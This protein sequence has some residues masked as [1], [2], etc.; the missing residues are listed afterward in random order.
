MIDPLSDLPNE[1]A[2]FST[3]ENEIA[4]AYTSW[5][6]L[7]VLVIDF[8][9]PP[10]QELSGSA[11]YIKNS[12]RQMDTLAISATGEFLVLLPAADDEAGREVIRRVRSKESIAPGVQHC[13][14]AGWASFGPDG[15][16]P[17]QLLAAARVR[18][19]GANS[20]VVFFP[21]EPAA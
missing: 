8:E 2:F 9:K 1:R 12:L 15:E 19:S 3:L 13:I 11:L 4:R 14:R 20:N 18:K 21:A 6:P 17:A 10:G 16:T 5:K 7:T